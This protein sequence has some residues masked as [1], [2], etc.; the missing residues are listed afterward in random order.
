MAT[1]YA[2]RPLERSPANASLKEGFRVHL[3]EKEL[4][5]LG[6]TNGDLI[7]LSSTAQAF[8]GFAVAWLAKQTNP[9]NKP[10]AKTSDL[11]REEYKLKLTDYIFIEK[12][13]ES[14]KPI[15]CVQV[16]W[17]QAADAL[18]KYSSSEELSFWIRNALSRTGPCRI[19]PSIC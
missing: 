3:S 6:L 12:A 18:S 8:N 9:G 15:D 16:S 2:L 14:W 7:R 4:K 1:G 19:A 17:V 13:T 5:N 11:L 10:I